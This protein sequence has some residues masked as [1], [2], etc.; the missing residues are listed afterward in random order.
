[1]Y[2]IYSHRSKLYH[3]KWCFFVPYWYHIFHRSKRCLRCRS[4]RRQLGYDPMARLCW[5]LPLR[6][7]ARVN[8]G[9]RRTMRAGV[10]NDQ[11][12]LAHSRTLEYHL[13][14]G[15]SKFLE[16][17]K[18]LGSRPQMPAKKTQTLQVLQIGPI[19]QKRTWTPWNCESEAGS[20]YWGSFCNV[21]CKRCARNFQH[22][23]DTTRMDTNKRKMFNF[24]AK[25]AKYPQIRIC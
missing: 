3:T 19:V 14:P 12:W 5:A 21:L 10:R 22:F 13:G 8:L 11:S 25:M 15:P 18:G 16:H 2:P 1:M 4:Q 7:T 6:G 17:F 23:Y 20:P 24:P 9:N